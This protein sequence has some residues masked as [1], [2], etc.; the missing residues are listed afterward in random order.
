M[1]EK[2][3][4][5]FE[6]CIACMSTLTGVTCGHCGRPALLDDLIYLNKIERLANALVEVSIN[7]GD[8]VKLSAEPKNPFEA[9]LLKLELEL[10]GWHYEGDGCLEA[11]AEDDDEE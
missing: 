7:T 6:F 10:K 9:A 11:M 5:P 2:S 8:Y 4:L 3:E 1:S